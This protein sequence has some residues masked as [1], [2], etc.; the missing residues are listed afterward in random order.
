MSILFFV[1]GEFSNEILKHS[2][3]KLKKI[4]N[5]KL[6]SNSNY[7]FNY[8]TEKY[9]KS[10]QYDCDIAISLGFSEKINI[11]KLN[12]QFGSYNIHQS[13]LPNYRG[14][15]P[16]Q[17]M[18]INSEKEYGCTLHVLDKDF[19]TG[20]IVLNT[21]KKFKDIPFE[22]TVK[23]LVI[24]DS[25]FLLDYLLKNYK[26]GFSNKTKQRHFRNLTYAKKRTPEDSEITSKLCFETIKNMTKALTGS[27]YK[28]FVLQNGKK[29][30]VK[31]VYKYN[32]KNKKLINFISRNTEIYLEIE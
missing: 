24:R 10:K 28:P 2:H 20:D 6:I 16:I 7:K 5:I 32:L 11:D 3:S 22:N 12:T 25:S 29:V 14:R 27:D 31:N 23:K 13:I 26:N 9:S 18:I 1:S 30:I 17:A 4:N 8:P 21:V 15:H 19:D